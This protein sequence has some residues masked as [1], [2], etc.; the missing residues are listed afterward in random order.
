MRAGDAMSRA[1]A[2]YVVRANRHFSVFNTHHQTPYFSFDNPPR[3]GGSANPCALKVGRAKDWMVDEGADDA[4]LIPVPQALIH[5]PR[6]LVRTVIVSAERRSI[7]C[8]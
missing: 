6:L 8:F 1:E 4:G 3:R 7:S 2:S 5:E